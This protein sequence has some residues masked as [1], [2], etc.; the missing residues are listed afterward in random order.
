MEKKW[1]VILSSD[2]CYD[3]E[4]G[5][6][7][8]EIVRE[9]LKKKWIDII[10][11]ELYTNLNNILSLN[12]ISVYGCDSNEEEHYQEIKCKEILE[13]LQK[14]EVPD[15][16][17]MDKYLGIIDIDIDRDLYKD[18]LKRYIRNN[19]PDEL[20]QVPIIDID[21]QHDGIYTINNSEDK[22]E[23]ETFDFKDIE[24]QEISETRFRHGVIPYEH[25]VNKGEI[26]N[27]KFIRK[28]ETLGDEIL[29]ILSS[30][31]FK[32]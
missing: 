16:I 17:I 3:K 23:I 19:E 2:L 11:E 1:V 12:R 27:M 28:W 21:Y 7:E 14:T 20:K 26:D 22:E 30:K 8:C 9:T 13:E 5:G 6:N 29:Y 31:K 10:N 18:G 32:K 25:I 15:C 24:N 4:K